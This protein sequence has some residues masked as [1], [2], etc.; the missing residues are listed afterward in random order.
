MGLGAILGPAAMIVLQEAP[1][2]RCRTCRA[3]VPGMLVTCRWCGN[4]VRFR[5]PSDLT[6]ESAPTPEVPTSVPASMA[7]PRI[8]SA[9]PSARKWI[10]ASGIYVGGSSLLTVGSRYNIQLDGSSLRVLGPVELNPATVA[11][12][13]A[14]IG[15]DAS[16]NDGRLVVNETRNGQARFI[17][18]FMSTKGGSS[19]SVAAKIVQAARTAEAIKP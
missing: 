18:I 7:P 1:P 15:L 13:R 6:A 12:E 4:D 2:A 14:L 10:I 19:E 17:L 8:D 3:P 5:V 11:L 16:G 9:S